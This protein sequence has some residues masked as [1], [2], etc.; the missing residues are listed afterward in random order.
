[1]NA[2]GSAQDHDAADSPES[3]LIGGPIQQNKDQAARA[4]PITYLGRGAPPPFLIMHGDQDPLVPYGQSVLL[5]KALRRMG[6]DVVF[7]TL[8][9]AGHGGPAFDDPAI[10]AI[11]EAFFDRV[12]G[13]PPRP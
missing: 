3:Q 8:P 2:M 1:M 11:V 10:R 5:Y 6:A 4:N 9:G 12:L 7:H 13:P